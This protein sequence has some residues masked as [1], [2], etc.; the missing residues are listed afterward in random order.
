MTYKRAFVDSDI[1]LDL[2]LK[3]D[4]FADYSLALLNITTQNLIKLYTSTLILANIHY[5]VS[6]NVNKQVALN[7]LKYIMNYVEILPFEAIHL[8]SA[9]NGAHADFEDSIQ[10]YIAKESG[11]DLIISRNIK[12]YSKF[13]MPVL[14]A[15]QILKRILL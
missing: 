11:C 9:I 7:S 14:T 12:H 1:L 8:N 2:L 15:E 6:K 10:Y 3:R 13:D 5:I 4:L